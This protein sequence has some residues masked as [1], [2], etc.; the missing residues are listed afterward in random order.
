MQS[1]MRRKA[2][3]FEVDSNS[4]PSKSWS[5]AKMSMDIT[6]HENDLMENSLMYRVQT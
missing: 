1:R 6:F 3:R 4:R 2:L 5:N